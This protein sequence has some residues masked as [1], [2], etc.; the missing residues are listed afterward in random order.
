MKSL[1]VADTGPLVVLAKLDHLHLLAQRYQNIKIPEAV[2]QEAT[3]LA[4]RRDSQQ[5]TGFVAKHVEVVT[6]LE[7]DAGENLDFGLDDGETQA[8]LLAQQCQCPVLMDEKRGR[9][10]A[11]REQ[12]EVLGT[13]GLLLAAKQEGLLSE[14]APLLDQMQE[15]K[16]RLSAGLIERAKQMAGEDR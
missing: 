8:I 4:H 2:F 12:V 10:V 9:A 1:I 14:L 3:A 5:I 15:Y 13:V 7:Q 6:H 16:Y 11:N